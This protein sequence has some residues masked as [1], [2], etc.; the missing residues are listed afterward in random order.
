[1]ALIREI[2]QHYP[3]LPCVIGGK[4]T[5]SQAQTRAV[6]QELLAA[7]F[8]QVFI[9]ADAIAAFETYLG[10]LERTSSTVVLGAGTAA[11]WT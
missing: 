11:C 9:E 7:G 10:T 3:H 1:M 2:R 6:R 4:L 5:T 8:N